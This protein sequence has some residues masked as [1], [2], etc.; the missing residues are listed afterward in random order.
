MAEIDSRHL[1]VQRGKEAIGAHDNW[2]FGKLIFPLTN[3]LKVVPSR[4]C[5]TDRSRSKIHD[6]VSVVADVGV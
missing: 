5:L 2:T 6:L 4:I 3:A 1:P